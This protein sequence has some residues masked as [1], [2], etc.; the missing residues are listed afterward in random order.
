MADDAGRARAL[1]AGR[2]DEEFISDIIEAWGGDAEAIRSVGRRAEDD[3]MDPIVLA[4]AARV[5]ERAGDHAAAAR[6][7][8]LVRLGPHYGPTTVDTGVGDRDPSRDAT[9]GTSTFYYGTYTYR[10]TTPMDLVV[11]GQPG[12]VVAGEP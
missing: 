12:L 11:P 3:P 6:Y 4:W 9:L 1:A 2:P 5:S 10:R 8:R 7:R